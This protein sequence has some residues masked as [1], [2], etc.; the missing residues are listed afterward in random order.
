MLPGHKGSLG[1][2]S[3]RSPC[4]TPSS[5]FLGDSPKN[6]GISRYVSCFGRNSGRG[7]PMVSIGK[8]ELK[9]L[10]GKNTS[11]KQCGKKASQSIPVGLLSHFSCQRPSFSRNRKKHN[12]QCI[13]PFHKKNKRNKTFNTI[14]NRNLYSAIQ[15]SPII[16]HVF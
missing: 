9:I 3:K 4:R 6:V 14:N 10:Q 2:P 5:V 8:N 13:S 11:S 1:S 16:I 7:M 12:V 15:T